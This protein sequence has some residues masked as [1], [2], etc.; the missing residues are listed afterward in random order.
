VLISAF[1]L[2]A[3]VIARKEKFFLLFA[4]PKMHTF[5]NQNKKSSADRLELRWSSRK[6]K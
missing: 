3:E 4:I 5:Y 1:K 6:G 2:F